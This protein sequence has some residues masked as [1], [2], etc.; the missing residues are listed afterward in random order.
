MKIEE[1]KEQERTAWMHEARVQQQVNELQS[2]LHEAE[3]KK[4]ALQLNV[5]AANFS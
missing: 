4:R 2:E 5:E 3:Q 1:I